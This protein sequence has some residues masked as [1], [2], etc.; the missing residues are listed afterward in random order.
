MDCYGDAPLENVGYAVID[1]DGDGIEELVI[2]TTE[3]FT[4]E[5]LWKVDSRAVHT[6]WRRHEAHSV[7]KHCP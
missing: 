2:G 6:G 4:D 7:S 3:R 1:L 5:I